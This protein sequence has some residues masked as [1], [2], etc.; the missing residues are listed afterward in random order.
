MKIDLTGLTDVTDKNARLKGMQVSGKLRKLLMDH[1]ELVKK[2]DPQMNS[3]PGFH[4]FSFYSRLV[5]QFRDIDTNSASPAG[6]FNNLLAQ[7]QANAAVDG[8][9]ILMEVPVEESV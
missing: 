2:V 9:E 7:L 4:L 5:A 6:S 1:P 8:I 3:I